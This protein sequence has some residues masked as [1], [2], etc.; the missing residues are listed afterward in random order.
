[1][2]S[3]CMNHLFHFNGNFTLTRKSYFFRKVKKTYVHFLQLIESIFVY[4]EKLA[5]RIRVERVKLYRI[6]IL[7][8]HFKERHVSTEI[9]RIWVFFKIF[10]IDGIVLEIKVPSCE[11]I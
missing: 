11:H 4:C 8:L 3:K 7:I 6:L 10:L 5:F 1:M 2:L 9:P